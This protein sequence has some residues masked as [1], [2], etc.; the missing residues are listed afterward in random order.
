MSHKK[1]PP[2]VSDYFASIGARGGA[3]GRGSAERSE[4]NRAAVKARWDKWRAKRAKTNGKA[5]PK[6]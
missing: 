4:L 3:A 5:K 6:K 2:A 1:I